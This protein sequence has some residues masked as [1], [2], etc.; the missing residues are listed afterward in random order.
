MSVHELQPTLKISLLLL[1]Q[2]GNQLRTTIF[3]QFGVA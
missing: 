3:E 1:P 2:L